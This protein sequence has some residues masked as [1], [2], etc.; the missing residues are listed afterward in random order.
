MPSLIA[1]S[2]W[3]PSAQV[4]GEPTGG[5]AGWA[6]DL[7]E[8]LGGVGLAI[9][10]AL[11]S[12]V[13]IVPADLVLP[14]V[15]YSANQ[16]TIGLVPAIAW[17][18]GGSTAGALVLYWIG[19]KLGRDRARALLTRIP[20]C[21]DKAID[22]SEEWFSRHGA[23]AV[24]IGRVFPGVRALISV[25]AGIERMPLQR[26][27]VLT[28]IGSAVWNG[29]LIGA[30]Y[31]L[32]SKWRQVTEAVGTSTFVFFAIAAGGVVWFVFRRRG[33]PKGTRSGG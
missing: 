6:F 4:S 7:I 21:N 12:M 33:R 31:A 29:T 25:P 19:L 15:G 32:G 26:F 11:D 3:L 23:Q 16:G 27:I 2:A 5:F 8:E 9:I 10:S 30:G 28:A 24:L 18:T 14:L 22:R 20:G 13:A 1:S 17:A